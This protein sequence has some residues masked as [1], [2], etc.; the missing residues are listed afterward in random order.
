M[1]YSQKNGVNPPEM[2]HPQEN[3]VSHPDGVCLK[4]VY[5]QGNGMSHK[6]VYT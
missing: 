5:T 2:A 6:V 3:G 1:V 4:M